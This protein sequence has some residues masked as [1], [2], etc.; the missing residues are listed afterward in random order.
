MEKECSHTQNMTKKRSMIFEYISFDLFVEMNRVTMEPTM[1]N[2]EKGSKIKALLTTY[3]VPYTSLGSGTNR[4]AVLI[5]GYA[6]KIALDKDGMIDNMREFIYAQVLYPYVVKV[7]EC[8]FGGFISISEYV[9]IFTL[10]DFHTYQDEMRNILEDISSSFL[11]GDVG[12]TGRNY[13]NWGIREDGTICMLD[14]AYIYSVDYK[15]FTCSC[16][17]ETLLCY[18][19]D[20]VNMR[21]PR[22]GR[23]YTFGQIRKK[24]TKKDQL[25][26]IG[27]ITKR[28]YVLTAP[29]QYVE[30][31]PEFEPHNKKNKKTKKKNP[32]KMLIKEYRKAEKAK[33]YSEDDYWDR[34]DD[35][36]ERTE[37]K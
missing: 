6:M 11:I 36:F 35:Y 8:N 20:Y 30:I 12:I 15:L 5:D 22:C 13:V 14:F 7:Y 29:E 37:N 27:D 23:K 33:K 24:V 16:D 26:E 34:D 18:D 3:G 32:T 2:N 4:M 17:G 21:C 9:S 10:D 1:D 25:K 28:G 19:K 31:N